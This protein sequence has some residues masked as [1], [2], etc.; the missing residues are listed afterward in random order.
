MDNNKIF[1]KAYKEVFSL[2]AFKEALDND[3]QRLFEAYVKD[4]AEDVA[5]EAYFHSDDFLRDSV[6]EALEENFCDENE[7]VKSNDLDETWDYLY[8]ILTKVIEDDEVDDKLLDEFGNYVV[9]EIHPAYTSVKEYYADHG[10]FKAT[11][12]IK[13]EVAGAM[14][15]MK[16]WENE[17]KEFTSNYGREW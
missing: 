16:D 6:E 7:N 10:E 1:E 5:C 3:C 17:S 14:E 13:D 11:K 15:T 2:D 4:N 9:H 12:A 8:G